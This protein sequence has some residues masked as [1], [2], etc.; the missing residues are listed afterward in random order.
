MNQKTN[1]KHNLEVIV[2]HGNRYLS[3]TRAFCGFHRFKDKAHALLLRGA[4]IAVVSLFV[5][6]SAAVFFLSQGSAQAQTPNTTINFQAR[7]LTSTGALVPDGN[8]NLEFKLYDSIAAGGTAQGVCSLNSSTDDCWWLE[9]RTGGNVVRVVNGYVSVNL[10]SVTAFGTSIPWSQQMFITMRVGGIGAPVW[11]ATEMTNA[12]NR[13][14]LNAAPLA[15][16]A[17]N[18]K[19]ADR[20]SANSDNITIQT[21]TT[22]TSGNSGNIAIDAGG[23]AGTKGTITLGATNAS[24]L[25][26][27]RAGLTTSNA[28][29]LTVTQLLTGN[30]GLTVT[31]NKSQYYSR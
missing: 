27:G 17:N 23:A 20:T 28:G 19:T 9:T 3:M 10:G 30:L 16:V 2:K 25:T 6:S 18:L 24:A 22:T 7:I 14:M 8:Y 1:K 4:L 31:G 5:P 11:D 12:G 15:L 26:L 29:A 13:M 21:G